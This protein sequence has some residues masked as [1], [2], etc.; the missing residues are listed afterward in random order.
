MN[1][2]DP[3]FF[4]DPYLQRRGTY[5][6]T[7]DALAR[8]DQSAMTGGGERFR[9]SFDRVEVANAVRR[10]AH[11]RV[12]TVAPGH[13]T[14]RRNDS[15]MTDKQLAQRIGG[16]VIDNRT[17]SENDEFLLNVTATSQ[18]HVM[19]SELVATNARTRIVGEDVPLTI[20][21]E[22][23]KLDVT[24]HLCKD[25]G[26]RHQRFSPL[27]AIQY[28]EDGGDVTLT[29]E[30]TGAVPAQNVYC[31]A[32]RALRDDAA[33]MYTRRNEFVPRPVTPD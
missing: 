30:A 9:I 27:A 33:N 23:E 17:C 6:R 1:W 7:K 13:I 21:N 11:D 29:F 8:S 32:V 5:K 2:I 24:V 15:V 3:C 20:L 28:T 4:D 10:F 12:P 14:I 25:C 16:L 22:G 26:A 31:D 18:R 19:A